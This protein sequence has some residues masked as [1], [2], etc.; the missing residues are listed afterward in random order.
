MYSVR[1]D[2]V[3]VR[4]SLIA[5]MNR[6]P[7]IVGLPSNHRGDSDHSVDNDLQVFPRCRPEHE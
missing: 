7:P 4:Y 1:L 2:P 6:P 5:E 3:D